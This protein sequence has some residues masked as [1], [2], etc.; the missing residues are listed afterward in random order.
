[1]ETYNVAILW[2]AKYDPVS[3]K[4]GFFDAKTEYSL[5]EIFSLIED[6]FCSKSCQLSTEFC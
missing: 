4:L 2:S 3:T 1:M 5:I 6:V